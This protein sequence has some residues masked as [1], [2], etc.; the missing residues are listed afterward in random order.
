M[1][2]MTDAAAFRKKTTK[3]VPAQK[4]ALPA[5]VLHLSAAD[6]PPDPPKVSDAGEQPDHII[7]RRL[8]RQKEGPREYEIEV[9]FHPF[10]SEE[11]R[12]EAYRK[13]V[14]ALFV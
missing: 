6:I 11:R 5:T 1:Y 7:E 10:P 9:F 14:E 13:W 8:I 4:R 12:R 2:P 3:M